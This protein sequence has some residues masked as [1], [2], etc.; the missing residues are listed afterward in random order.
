[1]SFPARFANKCANSHPVEVGDYIAINEYGQVLC[2]KCDE[3][4]TGRHAKETI[5]SLQFCPDCF[6]EISL[7]GNHDCW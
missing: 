3:F 1:M 4:T 5:Y 6:M 2:T 7:S